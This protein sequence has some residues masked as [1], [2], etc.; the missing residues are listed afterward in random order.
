MGDQLLSLPVSR[1]RLVTQAADEG[2]RIRVVPASPGGES[3]QAIGR[4]PWSLA[5]DDR[6]IDHFDVQPVAGFDAEIAPRL[7]RDDDLVLGADLYA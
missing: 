4:A 7:A 1:L 3:A 2:H 5:E 6:I